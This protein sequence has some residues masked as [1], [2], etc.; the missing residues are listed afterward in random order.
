MPKKD[1]VIIGGGG[2]AK[3]LIDAIRSQGAYKIA[4]IVDSALKRGSRVMGVP[5]LGPDK[6]IGRLGKRK[7]YLALGVGSARATE[8]REKIYKKFTGQGFLFPAIIHKRAYVPK[9]AKIGAGSQ[10]MAGAI[11]QPDAE[12]LENV[13]INT[14]GIVGHD[15][16]IG[17]HSHISIG[18]VLGGNV[19][20]GKCSHIGIGAN[21]LQGINIGS[22]VTVG[23]GSVVNKN[24]DNYKTVAG[25]PAR[26]IS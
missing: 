6:E 25:V 22:G 2:H 17:A 26:E 24:I 19:A 4:G 14:S 11:L 8:E 18:A 20:V 3:I 5:V 23:A 9:G 15:S 16:V 7:I 21:V 10:V 13:I 1:I 12:I